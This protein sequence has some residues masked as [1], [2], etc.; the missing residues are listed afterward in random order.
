MK[1]GEIY[2]KVEKEINLMILEC[3]EGTDLGFSLRPK[4]MNFVTKAIGRTLN[5]KNKEKLQ[6]E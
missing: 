2:N 1:D 3:Y 4:I 5:Y 6:N